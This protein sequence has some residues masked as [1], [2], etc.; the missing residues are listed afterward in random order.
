MC[1]FLVKS[2]YEYNK[3]EWHALQWYRSVRG[4]HRGPMTPQVLKKMMAKFEVTDLLSVAPGRAWKTVSMKTEEE[5]G[6]PVEEATVETTSGA[7]SVLAIACRT[8]VE[9]RSSQLGANG[10]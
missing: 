4:I 1:A 10:T 2:C 9:I 3:N 6:L 5:V 8:G 7:C